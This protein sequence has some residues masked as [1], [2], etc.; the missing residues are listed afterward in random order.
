M[1]Y[2]VQDKQIVFENKKVAEIIKSDSIEDTSLSDQENLNNILIE[3]EL[4]EEQKKK[5]IKN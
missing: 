3:K 4:S 1:I 5:Q 2:N